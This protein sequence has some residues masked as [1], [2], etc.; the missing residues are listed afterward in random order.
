MKWGGIAGKP[1]W[2]SPEYAPKGTLVTILNIE[3]DWAYVTYVNEEEGL[4]VCGWISTK[5]FEKKV[6][7][8]SLQERRKKNRSN[9]KEVE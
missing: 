9:D 2:V 6:F 5:Y 3:A 7:S 4:P 1:G 8:K